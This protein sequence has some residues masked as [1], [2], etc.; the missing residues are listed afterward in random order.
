MNYKAIIFDMDGTIVQTGGVWDK[1]V[2]QL[3]AKRGI[4]YTDDMYQALRHTTG[5]EL[6][7]SC[8]FIKEVAGLKDNPSALATEWRAQVLQLH[9]A[10]PITFVEGFHEFHR[11]T[12]EHKL[13]TGLATNACNT[14]FQCTAQRMKLDTYFGKHMYNISHVNQVGKPNPAI[15]LHTAQQLA[16][17]PK[18]CIAIE[19]SAHGIQAALNAGMLCIGITTSGNPDQTRNAHI[20]IDHYNEID[21]PKLLY[22]K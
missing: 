6:E 8:V 2:A 1:V 18:D 13:A 17:D 7:E 12:Q 14:S 9:E 5:M 19:D 4:S 16:V 22:T 21:L 11:S 3:L 15:Y 20:I 10:E